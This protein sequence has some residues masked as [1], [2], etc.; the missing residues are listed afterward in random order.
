MSLFTAMENITPMGASKIPMFK[1]KPALANVATN[2]KE[3]AH[4]GRRQAGR[5]SINVGDLLRDTENVKPLTNYLKTLE[6]NAA[7]HDIEKGDKSARRRCVSV[8][9]PS[10]IIAHFV[11]A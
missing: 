2:F 6:E 5:K 8:T 11:R 1:T 9:P 7:D 4:V 10:D 3:P